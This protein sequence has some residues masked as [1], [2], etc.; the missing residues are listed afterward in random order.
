MFRGVA[1]LNLDTKG[2]MA[3]PSRYRERLSERCEGQLVATIDTDE[4]CLLLYPLPEWEAIERK[5]DA[6]PTF[7]PQ[8]RRVQRLLMGHASDVDMDGNGRLL[9]P[10]P[11]RQYAGL[12]KRIVL[13][14]QGK[15]FE[16]WDEQLWQQKRD[17]WLAEETVADGELPAELE[18]L[19]L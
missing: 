1:E 10:P 19:S 4:R 13:I 18:S 8:A 15:K 6:L 11:L 7:N 14:G 3:I 2:R 5:L 9:L 12:E 16:I 17:E